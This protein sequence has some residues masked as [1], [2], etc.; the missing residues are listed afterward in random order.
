MA[1]TS[2]KKIFAGT[3]IK[4]LRRDLGLTQAQMA[5]D[6]GISTSYL[7]LLE[8]NQRP[9][10][11]QLLLRLADSFEVDL[12]DFSGDD[13]ARA[14]A[15]LKE[16]FA[17]PLFEGLSVAN[18]ELADMVGASPAAAQA[19][20]TLYRAY[21][22]SVTNSAALAERMESGTGARQPDALRQPLEEVRDFFTEAGNHF[23]ALEATAEL[24]WA[25]AEFSQS[26]LYWQ[27]RDYLKRSHDISVRTVPADVLADSRWRLDRHSKRLF[28]SQAL[29]LSTRTFVLAHQIGLLG[30]RD[31]LNQVINDAGLSKE[32]TP[33]ARLGLANYFAA[34]VMMPYESFLTTAEKWRYDADAIAARF[35]ASYEQVCHRFTALQ[36]P[37]ARG[38]PFFFLR[39][40][41]A[42]N[43]SKQLSAGGFHFARFGGAC[44]RWNI[45]ESF[46]SPGRIL[47]QLLEME[48]GTT[49]FTFSRALVNLGDG[50]DKPASLHAI[51]M[52]CR[53]DY[54]RK[55]VYADGIDLKNKAAITPAGTNC[56]LCERPD[57]AMRAFPPLNRRVSVPEFQRGASPFAFESW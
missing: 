48:D 25:D 35:G 45:Y 39:I 23:P 50:Y 26:D 10:S 36:R 24:L 33:L 17:D 31:L 28:V 20:V 32:A 55:L 56:R 49:Y 8:R 7:N 42:G 38:V 37:G 6:L 27:L 2:D 14:A 41:H 40:D 21:R 30:H 54:V 29:D 52:G 4:R 13:E 19:V 5:D 34:A 3:R 9:L 51:G 18:A 11:A 22:N 47:P 53:V 57:C 16:V 15:S 12:K 46:Q 43:I 1:D 44:P